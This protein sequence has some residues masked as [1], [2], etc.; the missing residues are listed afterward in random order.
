MRGG[1]KADCWQALAVAITDSERS[2][3][4]ERAA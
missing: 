3:A 2:A 1:M 4:T